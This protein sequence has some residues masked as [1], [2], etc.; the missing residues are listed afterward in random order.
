MSF[1]L[2]TNLNRKKIILSKKSVFIHRARNII[3]SSFTP[4]VPHHQNHGDYGAIFQVVFFFHMN[5]NTINSNEI[6]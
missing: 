1:N 6:T 2:F 5:I 4:H 3:L